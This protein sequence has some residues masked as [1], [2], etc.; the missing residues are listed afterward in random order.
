METTPPTML[1]K[2]GLDSSNGEMLLIVI[3]FIATIEEIDLALIIETFDCCEVTDTTN[4][5]F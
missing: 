2:G 3:S 5:S 4:K 1:I